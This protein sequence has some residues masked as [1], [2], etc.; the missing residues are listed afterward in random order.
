ML[1]T[2]IREDITGVLVGQAFQ[3]DCPERKVEVRLESLT[4]VP[5]D[6]H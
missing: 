4:Y 1:P 6:C 5:F 3:P 2:K